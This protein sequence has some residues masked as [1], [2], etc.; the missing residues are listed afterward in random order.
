[1]ENSN[2]NTTTR[3][4]PDLGLAAYLHMRGLKM[5][6]LQGNKGNRQQH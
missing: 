6:N 5:V 4:T 2:Q 1:M 3:E